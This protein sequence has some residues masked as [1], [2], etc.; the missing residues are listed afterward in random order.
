VAAHDPARHA[1]EI[2]ELDAQKFR[3]AKAASDLEIES[4]RLEGD[5]EMFKERL[6]ELEAQGLEGDETVRREREADDATMYV[7]RA[8]PAITRLTVTDYGSRSIARLEST[9][10]P[11]T[12][13]TTT[14][15]LSETVARAMFMWSTSIRNS[16]DSSMRT[17][18]GK[19]CKAETFLGL[20]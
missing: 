10:K 18:S 15:L 20:F 7:S 8:Y 9:L 13:E 2:L 12:L 1:Q 5:L 3:I 11:T 17:T 6:A 19:L 14:R 4:E 16:L